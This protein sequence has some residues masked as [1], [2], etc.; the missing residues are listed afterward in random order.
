MVVAHLENWA[1]GPLGSI[2]GKN[3][4]DTGQL[5]NIVKV[6]RF[7]AEVIES[8]TGDSPFIEIGLIGRTDAA[9][10]IEDS[11]IGDEVAIAETGVERASR[12]KSIWSP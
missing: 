1:T 10:A 8:L 5:G 6:E 4:T 2:G 7:V 3:N 12:N 11:I 9:K